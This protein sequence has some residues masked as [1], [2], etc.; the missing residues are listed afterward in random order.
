MLNRVVAFFISG[1]LV[2]LLL[3]ASPITANA[4]YQEDTV[5]KTVLV[6]NFITGE[7]PVKNK[8]IEVLK[9]NE[10]AKR[11]VE[12]A[13][14]LNPADE[15][16]LNGN[17][18]WLL[19][20]VAQELRE[21]EA[22]VDFYN[23]FLVD[24]KK[25]G[26]GQKMAAGYG[27]LIQILF[28][29]KKYKECEKLCSEF[30]DITLEDEAAFI[31]ILRLKPVVFRRMVLCQSRLG[32]VDKAIE[33]VE[34]LYKDQPDNWL[35]LELKARILREVG[36]TVDAEKAYQ[37]LIK[38]IDSD[39]RLGKEEKE[40]FLEEIKYTLSNVYVELKK[41]DKAAD[42]LKALVEKNPDNPTYHNDLGYIWADNNLNLEEAE[43]LIRKAIEI[44]RGLRKKIKNLKPE[45]DKDNS[46][47]LDSLAWVLFKK[48]N[49]AEAKKLLVEAIKDEEGQHIEILD[50]L[51][52]IHYAMGEKAEA[53]KV[54][55]DAL[56]FA[57]TSKREQ[58]KKKEVEKK[59]EKNK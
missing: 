10:K 6:F 11:I 59:I 7:E 38:K 18:Y 56:N 26:S 40:E 5:L 36:R 53:T 45:F 24:A 29:T 1:I 58:D 25:L 2:N 52:D 27:P 21:N 28:D 51:G 33:R 17:A 22:A 35:N 30:L 4:F 42:I 16:K 34:K 31:P 19:A 14:K 43:K 13:Q 32:E 39:K 44:E 48:K 9:N 46:A 57:G 37:D 3:I 8:I 15:K 23:K 54:W 47:Y 55:K 20:R 49:Y 41:I 12:G 50:H